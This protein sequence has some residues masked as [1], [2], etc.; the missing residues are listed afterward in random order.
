MSPTPWTH[1]NSITIEPREL[2]WDQNQSFLLLQK[3]NK[4]RWINQNN[5][6]WTQH[7]QTVQPYKPSKTCGFTASLTGD[8]VDV[9]VSGGN[10]GE[11]RRL[12]DKSLDCIWISLSLG[13]GTSSTL[14]LLKTQ[15]IIRSRNSQARKHPNSIVEQSTRNS[16]L[17]VIECFSLLWRHWFS[18]RI[19]S[20]WVQEKIR[21]RNQKLPTQLKLSCYR[22]VYFS[23]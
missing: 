7:Q 19:A 20:W 1:S 11:A 12:Y 6:Y 8:S 16:R 10:T 17:L 14:N 13:E 18:K 9:W 3:I 4:E 21:F 23:N 22:K 5:T 2:W 15:K